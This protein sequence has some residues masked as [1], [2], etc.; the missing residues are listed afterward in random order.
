MNF[1]FYLD[2]IGIAI[3]HKFLLPRVLKFND[4]ILYN[5]GQNQNLELGG[6]VLLLAAYSDFNF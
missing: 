3:H 6:A 1:F 4:I 5:H 2:K